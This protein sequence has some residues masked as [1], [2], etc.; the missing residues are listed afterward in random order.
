MMHPRLLDNDNYRRLVRARDLIHDAYTEPLR[1]VDV[2]GWAHMSPFHF[3]R[4][5]CS[6]FGETPHAC[7][8]RLRMERAKHLLRS[9]ELPVTEV[10]FESGFESLGSFSTRFTRYTGCAPSRYRATVRPLFNVPSAYGRLVM[11][12]CFWLMQSGAPG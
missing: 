9:G 3:H 12:G 4:Q 5:F 8:T 1:L 6:A 10:C 11:P 2:A 7:L